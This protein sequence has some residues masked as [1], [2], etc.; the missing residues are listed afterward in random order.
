MSNRDNDTM[1]TETSNIVADATNTDNA[2]NRGEEMTK[3]STAKP[4][5]RKW[6]RRT[7]LALGIVLLL[8][9]IAVGVV[10]A[11][12]GPIAEWYVE[13]N[14]KEL[15]GRT[16]TMDDLHLRLFS[17]TGDVDNIVLYEADDTTHF[18]AM[19]HVDVSMDVWDIL[20]G[21][22]HITSAHI[23]NP[24]IRVTQNGDS[25]N[26]DDMVEFIF[27]E[28]IL[29]AMVETDDGDEWLIT[30]ENIT[31]SGGH[32]EY[33]DEEIEQRWTLSDME[34]HTDQL[35]MEDRMSDIEVSMRINEAPMRGVLQ[36]NYDSFDFELNGTLDSLNLADTY[37]YW[38]PY[39]NVSSVDGMVSA[40]AHI[41]GNIDNIWA[42]NIAGDATIADLHI[43][44]PDGRDMLTSKHVGTNIQQLNIDEERYVLGSLHATDYF[45]QFVMADDGSTNFDLLFYGEPEVSVETTTE[46][47]ANDM[48]D[49][50]ERV[51]ITTNE[52]VAP[53][54]DITLR[55]D[56]LDLRDGRLYFADNTMHKPFEYELRRMNIKSHNFDIM[57]NNSLTITSDM[58]GHGSATIRWEGSLMDFYNQSLL[59][60]LNNVDIKDFSPYIEHF[61]A[62]PVRSGNLTFQSQNVIT[63]GELNGVNRLGTYQ[64]KVDKKDK[65]IDAE[66][67]L[68]LKLGLFFLTDNKGHIDIDLPIKGHIDSPEFSYRKII[69]KAIGN[70]LL[71]VVAS[72]FTW[73]AGNKQDA[74]RHI[75]IDAMQPAFDSEQYARIDKMAEALAEDDELKVRLTQRLNY[76]NAKRQIADLDLKIAYY[77]STRTNPNE[78][79]DMLDFSAI[80]QMRMSNS[81]IM[82]YADSQL[83]TRGIDPTTLRTS[84]KAMVLY[85]DMV[86]NQLE[87]MMKHRDRVLRDY[88][89][90]QH[91]ELAADRFTIDSIDIE[92]IRSYNGKDRYTIALVIDDEVVEIDS[93]DDEA[94]ATNTEATEAEQ[95]EQT[96]Q[97]EQTEQIEQ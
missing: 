81:D 33:I 97:T 2:S 24:V 64:F 83:I 30:V 46:L 15:V 20:D 85:G 32:I 14:S 36:F 73:M 82:I 19:E 93:P 18:V 13:K 61:T 8:L 80:E 10:I 47:V 96:E 69:M 25:F 71:K 72:P 51:T 7:L 49:V 74:F 91:S 35:F 87:E 39:M 54:E 44:G 52:E 65:Q 22:L 45:T 12:L 5:R 94:E 79:L 17:G 1:A 88:I 57:G 76:Q 66:F 3:P 27:V 90:F 53:F 70:V 42:M 55:I 38:T 21:H 43:T 92:S 84:E 86:D 78:R 28:Y 67:N 37:K 31:I 60:I 16:I 63:N 34:L 68:P 23:Q 89:A 77:N 41:T 4:K 75:N 58:Q 95:S 48:Y 62:F 6:L 56:T 50:K 59:A 40:D 29:P 9:L 11:W 26:F